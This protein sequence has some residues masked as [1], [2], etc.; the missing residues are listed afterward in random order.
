MT[1]ECGG[2][3]TFN[4][5]GVFMTLT[6]DDHVCTDK[7]YLYGSK[8]ALLL[9]RLTSGCP[10]GIVVAS[11]QAG[12]RGL[13]VMKKYNTSNCFDVKYYLNSDNVSLC[14]ESYERDLFVAAVKSR[15]WEMFE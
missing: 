6:L 11:G 1:L 3:I 13:S 8:A 4:M 12:S 7:V 9:H 10:D 2:R 15:S 14:M 5:D